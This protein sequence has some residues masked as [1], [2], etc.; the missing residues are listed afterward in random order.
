MVTSENLCKQVEYIITGHTGSRA[1]PRVADQVFFLHRELH[2]SRPA[3]LNP[4]VL[5]YSQRHSFDSYY[6][7]F[8]E[9]PDPQLSFWSEYP[10]RRNTENSRLVLGLHTAVLLSGKHGSTLAHT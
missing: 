2:F 3:K 1:R 6:L 8:R 4:D 7:L 10:A 5:Q 9:P